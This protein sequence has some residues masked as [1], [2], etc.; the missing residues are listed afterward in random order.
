MSPE[1]K[2]D[3]SEISLEEFVPAQ[4]SFSELVAD[5]EQSLRQISPVN[6]YPRTTSSEIGWK[7]TN[8]KSFEKYSRHKHG[9]RNITKVF[10]WPP[11]GTF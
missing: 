6:K 5:L 4:P 3:I 1:L 8:A 9:K 2:K 7:H 11:E 10:N